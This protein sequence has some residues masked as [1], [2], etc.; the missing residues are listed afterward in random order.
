VSHAPDFVDPVADI[1]PQHTPPVL[2]VQ[3][4][5]CRRGTPAN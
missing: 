2:E 4:G 1:A 3:H 5:M